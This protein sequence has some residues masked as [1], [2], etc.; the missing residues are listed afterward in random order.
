[1]VL[2]GV[3]LSHP[4][5]EECPLRED[6]VLCGDRPPQ[7]READSDS[8]ASNGLLDEVLPVRDPSFLVLSAII[9][10]QVLLE[11]VQSLNL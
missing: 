8:E 4:F 2:H 1:M 3:L 5:I 11:R 7:L 10:F 6:L 9:T